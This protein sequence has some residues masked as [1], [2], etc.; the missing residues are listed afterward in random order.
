MK[1]SEKINRRRVEVALMLML[2][3][4]GGVACNIDTAQ[5]TSAKI[6]PV[7]E[8]MQE[9][10]IERREIEEGEMLAIVVGTVAEVPIKRDVLTGT[11]RN[12][13]V[14]K[15][16]YNSG[17]IHITVWMSDGGRFSFDVIRGVASNPH[18]TYPNGTHSSGWRYAMSGEGGNRDGSPFNL[19]R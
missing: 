10:V 12:S 19:S 18:A 4:G 3:F 11:I 7:Q 1:K 16:V 5:P 14:T 6:A 15:T 13:G 9:E 8:A 2:L 17:R